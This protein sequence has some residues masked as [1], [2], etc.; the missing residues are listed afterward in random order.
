MIQRTEGLSDDMPEGFIATLVFE[1][2]AKMIE[3]EVK[4]AGQ[5]Y[6]VNTQACFLHS[7]YAVI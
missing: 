4:E 3:G 2:E 1:E 7:N 5:H 6:F